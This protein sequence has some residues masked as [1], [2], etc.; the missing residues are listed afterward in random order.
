MIGFF[1]GSHGDGAPF[2]GQGG[3]LAHA[4]SPY[5]GGNIHMDLGENWVDDVDSSGE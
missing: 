2:D 1:A 3:Q 5:Y 4:F